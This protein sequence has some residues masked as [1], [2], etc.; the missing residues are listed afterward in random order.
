M[1]G[2]ATSKITETLRDLGGAIG[3]AARGVSRSRIVWTV[4]GI[5]ALLVL[6]S[7]LPLPSPVQMRDWA[8]SVGPWFPLAFLIAHIVATVVPFPRTAFTL[9]AG[10]LFGPL[11]GV[12]IAVV[13]STASAMIAMLLVRAAG[14]R[15]NRLVR[16]RS[17]DTVEER[18]R[19]RGWL[20]IVSLRL[21]PAVP[22]SVLNYA[23]G[24]SSVRVLP[25]AVATL[26][27]LLP[28]TTAVVVLGDALAGHVSALL[29]L[30]SGV[31]SAL[32]LTGLIVEIRHFRRHHRRARR[33]LDGE[34]SPEPATIS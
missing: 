14:W 25:Y 31:T 10:L 13:A 6:A 23:A 2:S 1:T 9:A 33:P 34:P 4:V 20:A 11:L 5:T 24:A 27:G 22:F 3:V 21:I 15:L 16:H 29:Y 17:I 18:L 28:G 12:A 30:V 32:G 7:L 8:Q 26:A 19:Q